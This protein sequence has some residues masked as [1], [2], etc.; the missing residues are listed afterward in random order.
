MPEAKSYEL[1]QELIWIEGA[2]GHAN[3]YC[4][5]PK[6]HPGKHNIENAEPPEKPKKE[7]DK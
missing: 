5:R 4:M 2:E 3:T 7:K 1:C 6:G